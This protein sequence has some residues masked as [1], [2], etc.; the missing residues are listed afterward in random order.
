MNIPTSHFSGGKLEKWRNS[1]LGKG[2]ITCGCLSPVHGQ[3]WQ[4]SFSPALIAMG[5]REEAAQT[6]AML[7]ASALLKTGVCAGW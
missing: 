4:F 2:W 7:E 3:K 6:E 5:K 1:Q